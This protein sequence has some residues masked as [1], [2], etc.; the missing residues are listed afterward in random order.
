MLPALATRPC[1]R[2]GDPKPAPDERRG[3]VVGGWWDPDFA[4]VE[5]GL[6]VV[7]R[8]TLVGELCPPAPRNRKP[9]T[10]G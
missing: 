5:D 9:L 8:L 3:V 7:D 2:H 4:N 10:P 6:T 1:R